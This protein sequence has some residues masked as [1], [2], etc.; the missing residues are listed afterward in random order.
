M[1]R[2]NSDSD[3]N[4]EPQLRYTRVRQIYKLDKNSFI[5][6][7]LAFYPTPRLGVARQTCDR[8]NTISPSIFWQKRRS[9]RFF[10]SRCFYLAVHDREKTPGCTATRSTPCVFAIRA[11]VVVTFGFRSQKAEPICA[12]H[13]TVACVCAYANNTRS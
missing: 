11:R 6:L 8:P 4:Q 1:I 5:L 7:K 13:V 12:P 2:T 10:S 3:I 9:P